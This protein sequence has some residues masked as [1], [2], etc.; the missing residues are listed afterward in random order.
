MA[1][2]FA[3]PDSLFEEFD[4]EPVTRFGQSSQKD[5]NQGW[6]EGNHDNGGGM[7]VH[8][9]RYDESLSALDAGNVSG[10][11]KT[12]KELLAEAPG[13]Q[14]TLLNHPK[15]L[16]HRSTIELFF[17]QLLSNDDDD[18]DGGKGDDGIESLPQPLP[19]A[20]NL[21][22]PGLLQTDAGFETWR[23]TGCLQFY[24]NFIL[25]SHGQPLV[26]LTHELTCGWDVPPFERLIEKHIPQEEEEGLVPKVRRRC[27]IGQ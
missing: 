25:D 3:N 11:F 9:G 13:V 1:D 10:L 23:T 16:K 21:S 8:G 5:E 26:Q 24:P 7:E 19:T 22:P 2:G 15:F 12:P 17:A 14:L 6:D 18:V 4:R 27:F 20:I